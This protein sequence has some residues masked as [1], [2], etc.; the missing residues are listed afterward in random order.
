MSLVFVLGMS[1]GILNLIAG[2]WWAGASIL[3]FYDVPSLFITVGGSTCAMMV[4]YPVWRLM[5][6]RD[7]FKICLMEKSYDYSEL[8][9]TIISFSEKSRREGLLSLEDDLVDLNDQF[10][11]M[12]IQLVVDGNDPELVRKVLEIEIEQ[13]VDRHDANK[14]MF[15][16]WSTFAP[17]FG[18]IGTLMGLVMMLVNLADKSSVGKNLAIAIITTFYGAVMTY[19]FFLPM[20]TRLD[21]KTNEETLVKM[22]TLEGILSVQAGENPRIVKDKLIMYL[23]PKEREAI[24]REV[25]K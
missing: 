22:I 11:K 12:G 16:D 13:M 23:P 17:A 7:L 2:V 14:R 9:M 24:S 5:K 21:Q 19:L 20:G 3:L 4:A 1:V 25:E 15:D 6:V 18:M 10:M 8:I